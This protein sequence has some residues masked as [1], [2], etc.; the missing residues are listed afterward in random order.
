VKRVSDIVSPYLGMTERNL[1][2]AFYEA[3]TENAVLL[4]DEVDSFLQDRRQAQRSWEIT[5]VNEMLVQMESF[6]GV[7]VASTNLMK[8]LD[9]AAL[10][11]FD[12]KL[13]FSYLKPVQAWALFQRYAT[14]LNLPETGKSIIEESLK[15][16]SKLT[17]GDFAAV[18]RQ[19]RFCP[20]VDGE[21]LLKAL[22][23]ECMMKDGQSQ[24]SIGF[25]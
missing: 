25:M 1:A 18:A 2:Q 5:A 13:N 20:I 24:T 22:N 14:V 17:P 6:N 4:L 16:M 23:N 7:F 12:L 21:T 8:G 19:A 3:D 11:R 10:R 9:Q 15:R